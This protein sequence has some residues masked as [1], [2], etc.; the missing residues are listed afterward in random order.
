[1]RCFIRWAFYV[2]GLTAALTASAI[3][4]PVSSKLVPLVPPGCAIVAGFENGHGPH[5]GGRLLLTTPNNQLD[6]DDW[7]ALAGVD[8]GRRY[9]EV[10]EAAAPDSTGQLTKHL[11]LVAGRFDRDRIFR[12]AQQN[13]A[14]TS[15]SEGETVLLVKPFPREQRMMTETRWLAIVNN[16]TALLGSPMLVQRA[17]QLYMTHAEAD[18]AL[19]ER[20]TPFRPD[21]TS[22]NV[23]V[24]MQK[25]LPN[26]KPARPH[27]VWA[28]LLDD[29]D[30]LLVG[31]HFGARIRVDFFVHAG[32]A[33]ETSFLTHKADLFRD[34]FTPETVQQGELSQRP[35]LQLENLSVEHN[36]VQGSIQLSDKQFGD[37]IVHLGHPEPPRESER[38]TTIAGTNQ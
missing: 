20:L 37:W 5:T 21:I 27:S 34:M 7:L 4:S 26:F 8:T 38:P 31:A 11:L 19:I 3:A 2:A 9:D 15:Q 25:L 12:A 16:R 18:S 30:V 17:L 35:Q 32:S 14:Q 22:W 24:S 10:I 1:M 6:L 13:G 33:R 29:A 28:H 23:I 36:E